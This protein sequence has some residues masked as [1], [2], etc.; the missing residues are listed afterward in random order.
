VNAVFSDVV[1]FNPLVSMPV[2]DTLLPEPPFEADGWFPAKFW[3]ANR[4][5]D[6]DRLTIVAG[7]YNDVNSVERLYTNLTLESVYADAA[8]ADFLPPVVWDSHAQA[9]SG[10]VRF[11]IDVE[12]FDSD[13]QRV[14]V[15]YKVPAGSYKGQWWSLDLT[16]NPLTGEWS[17]IVPGLN[18]FTVEYFVQAMDAAGNVTVSNNKSF[19]YGGDISKLYVPIVRR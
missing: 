10:G 17:R 3:A 13:V 9:V 6:P 12:D 5:G 14:L 7:Q 11:T 4:F 18:A 2:T 19:F 15:T 1:N 16:V 8:E